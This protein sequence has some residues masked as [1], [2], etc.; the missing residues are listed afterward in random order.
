MG[1]HGALQSGNIR[2]MKTF[3]MLH[4]KDYSEKHRSTEQDRDKIENEVRLH[5]NKSWIL[6]WPSFSVIARLENV[7]VTLAH[8]LF[9]IYLLD[10][11]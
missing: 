5:V 4:G 6:G 10:C 11:I 7:Q 8:H 9:C 1:H 2:D 3:V